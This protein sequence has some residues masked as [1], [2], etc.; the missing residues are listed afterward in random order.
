MLWR[1]GDQK[2]VLDLLKLVLKTVV[3]TM[4]LLGIDPV[5]STERAIDH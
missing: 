1:P 2:T 5:S 3:S 4:W